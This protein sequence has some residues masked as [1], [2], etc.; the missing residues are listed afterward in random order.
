LIA[1]N[2][3]YGFITELENLNTR[4]QKGKALISLP[5]G[6]LPLSPIYIT[7]NM[8]SLYVVSITNEGR[9][10]AFPLKDLPELPKGKGNKIVNISPKDF[11]AGSDYLKHLF[12]IPEE[13][14]LTMFSGRRHF[15]LT[16]SN[17]GNFIGNRAQRG[18]RLP[19]GL[20]NVDSVAVELPVPQAPD[21][22]ESEPPE[23]P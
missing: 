18:K 1:S 15:K 3:G 2:A 9:M 21:R 6:A 13:G 19:R 11:K 23:N 14:Q 8:P 16:F 5:A 17:L 22:A 12:L 4:N 7:G 10:L 20:A